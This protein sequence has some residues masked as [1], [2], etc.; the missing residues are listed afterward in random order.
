MF[1]YLGWMAMANKYHNDL[2][3][4]AYMDGIDRLDECL[5]RKLTDTVDTDRKNDLNILIENMEC[6]RMCAHRL[7]DSAAPH[8]DKNCKLGNAYPATYHGLHHW[9]KNKFEK[10][11][12]MCLAKKHGNILKVQSYMNS[13][14][15]L[16]ASLAKKLGE[17]KED[18]RKA[19]IKIIWEDVCI[20]QGAAHKLLDGKM[21]HSK[22]TKKNH[23]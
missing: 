1:E 21:H 13:I 15:S 7:L 14:E 3:I 4:R 8:S 2:K 18:D 9:M 23:H 6:L 19:D 20:L 11:G 12:W 5:K 22:R 10:L 17:L 16:Y